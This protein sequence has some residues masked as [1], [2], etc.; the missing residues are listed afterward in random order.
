MNLHVVRHGQTDLNK[1]QK[2]QGS[3][4]TDLNRLGIAQAHRVAGTLPKEIDAVVSSPM[5]RA[6]QTAEI[7]SGHKGV[8]V[9]TMAE[10]RERSVGIFEGLSKAE[11]K[12]KFP[13]VWKRR[14][15]HSFD[16][17]PPGGESVEE[18]L[19]RVRRGM[20]RLLSL[21]ETGD[22]VLVAH[23]FIARTVWAVATG[24]SRDVFFEYALGN[25]G[26]ASYAIFEGELAALPPTSGPFGLDG[27]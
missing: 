14:P 4:E 8:A 20:E 23:G 26:C 11:I 18:V 2:Y 12:A 9:Q 7:I 13:D 25:G 1:L 27:A 10:F 17:A 5:R 15:L 24:A 22:V 3:I 6:L 19:E 16:A 21:Y